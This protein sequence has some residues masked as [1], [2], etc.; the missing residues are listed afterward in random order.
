MPDEK[1][2]KTIVGEL[3]KLFW[4]LRKGKFAPIEDRF[5]YEK[6]MQQLPPVEREVVQELTTFAD[7][8]KYFFERDQDLG[9][10]IVEAIFQVHRLP[11]EQRAA[12][13]RKINQILMKRIADAGEG[14]PIRQ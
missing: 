12:R 8:S 13:T 3:G 11:I 6:Q 14:S 4:E 5:E 2:H 7:L 9:A 10:D 1:F